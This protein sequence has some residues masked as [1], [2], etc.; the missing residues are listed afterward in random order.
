MASAQTGYQDPPDVIKD[1]VTRAPAPYVSISP[2]G[3][4][5]LLMETEAAPPVSEL[6]KP[7]QRLAGMRL[8]A[9]TNDNFNPR[10]VVGLSLQDVETGEVRKVKLPANSDVADQE[11][12]PDGRYVAFSNTLEDRMELWILDTRSGKARKVMNEGANFI[13]QQ[14]RWLPDGRLLVLTIPDDRGPM[15]KEPLTP[16]GPAIQEA[17]GGQDAQTRTYQDLLKDPYDEELY[18]WLASS[19]PVI[20]RANGRG[21]REI[22]EPRIYTSVTPSPNGDYFLMQWLEKPFSYQVP[23]SR[24][25]TKTAVFDASGQMVRMIADQPLADAL[26]V[27]GVVTGRREVAWHPTEP[28]LLVWAE[29]QDGGDPKVETDNREDIFALEAPFDGEPELIAEL[30]D[31]YFGFQGIEGDDDVITM[32]YDRDTREIRQTLIDVTGEDDPQVVEFRNYQDDYANQGNF[33]T[34]LNDAGFSVIRKTNGAV[35]LAGEGASPEG[36]RP[37]LRKLDLETLEREELWRNSGENFEYVVGLASDDATSFVTSYEDPETPPNYRLHAK[38]KDVR[39]LTD[40]DDPHPELT[41]ISREIITY[42]RDDGVQLTAT[43]YL[44]PEYQ[45][46]DKLPVVVWAYP[47]EYSDAGTAGQVR[48]SDYRFTR[49][50]GYSHLFFLTQGY[51]VMDRAAMPVVGSDPETV[52][53]TF[54]EQIVASGQAAVD[55]TVRRGFGDGERIGVGGHS[56]GA[57]MTANLLAHSDIF[58][59]GIARSGAYNRTLTPFGFQAERRIFW[60][61]PETYYNL[62]PFMQADQ[63]NEPLLLIHG[64]KDNNSG[65]YPQQSER[66]FAAVKGTGGMARLV[67]LPHES[68]GYR[69][70]ES[71]LHTLAE[72]IDWFDRFVKPEEPE[73]A[74]QAA[75]Q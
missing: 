47:W 26:P 46:G 20:I 22:G 34:T 50:G 58:R 57:F 52:N 39:F 11:W 48:D 17:A 4:T 12:S 24:F 28:A 27:G 33:I 55:E 75:G 70:L 71:Q 54:I 7:M 18:S 56:Y 8:D 66:M 44:P 49:I 67:M 74:D 1:I 3:A 41:G 30:E 65:T 2:D 37:F 40:F 72:M 23:W 32:E 59:A 15:P 29:T 45:E 25:P 61:A 63:V 62:S 6:A 42:E 73:N 19:Q 38:G 21:Q 31:R 35:F 13:Y 5:M 69:G 9:A 53:D 43:L 10:N 14:P 16:K 36:L 68:H 51:A 60:D 64:D